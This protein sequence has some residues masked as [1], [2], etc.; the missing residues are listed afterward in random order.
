MIIA[1][2][3]P[4]AEHAQLRL[5][6]PCTLLSIYQCWISSSISFSKTLCSLKS[7]CSPSEPVVIVTP[8]QFCNFSELFS[9]HHSPLVQITY[10]NVGQHSSL[11][12]I[13]I[14]VK[15]CLNFPILPFVSFNYSG[16]VI[17]PQRRIFYDCSISS[18][19]RALSKGFLEN[20][21]SDG[22]KIL[23][24]GRKGAFEIL[25]TSL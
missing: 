19:S 25:F 5:L 8:W 12:V 16:L 2:L 20:W 1:N 6:S 4:I 3:E 13:S 15:K 17:N 18:V 14:T 23:V 21:R 10:K 22:T 9:L 7:F 24:Y 11:V